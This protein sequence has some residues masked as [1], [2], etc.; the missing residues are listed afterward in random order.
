MKPFLS[1]QQITKR[2]GALT[3]VDAVDLEVAEGEFLSFL[4]PSGSG[5]STLLY[6]IAGIE[7]ASGG[8][9]RIRGEPLLTVPP[10]KRD[11]GMVFQR[12]TLF[13]TMTVDENIAFPLRVRGWPP[14]RIEKRVAEMLDLV[15]LVGVRGRMP[16]QLSG[17]QQQRIALARA[18]AYDPRILLM[19]EPLA[20]LDKKL[21]EEIQGEIRRIHRET[22]VTILYVTHDQEEA[23]R[24][25]DRIAVFNRGRIEQVA[26]PEELYERPS[27]SFVAGFVGNSNF[28]SVRIRSVLDGHA[29]ATFPDGSQVGGLKLRDQLVAGDSARMLLRPERILVRPSVSWDAGRLLVSIKDV[30]YL[31]EMLDVAAETSWGQTLSARVSRKQIEDLAIRAGSTATI[32]WPDGEGVCFRGAPSDT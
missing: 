5:K 9:I 18:L 17:G 26:R 19:D 21:K 2:Y 27:T 30:T 3:A 11:I 15:R 16:N 29:E 8:Q 10:H 28:L 22:G 14:A 13:P 31:G 24:L 7:T 12:Y 4:G 20:A 1:V 25:A 32:D 6:V 23:L